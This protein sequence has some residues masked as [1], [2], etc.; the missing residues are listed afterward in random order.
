MDSTP[1]SEPPSTAPIVSVVAEVTNDGEAVGVPKV[2]VLVGTKGAQAPG[3]FAQYGDTRKRSPRSA[4]D[5]G[6]ATAGVDTWNAGGPFSLPP[7]SQT[8]AVSPAFRSVEMLLKAWISEPKKLS[9]ESVMMLLFS[10]P[11]PTSGSVAASMISCDAAFVMWSR[12]CATVDPCAHPVGTTANA[13]V[14]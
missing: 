6:M 10:H 4:L 5:E 1:F 3:L 2:S 9:F 8:S 7:N 14:W 12:T 11:V 13:N